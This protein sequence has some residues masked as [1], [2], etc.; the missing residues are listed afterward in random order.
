[1]SH[2]SQIGNH[3]RL[4]RILHGALAAGQVVM[5]GVF[6]FVS[7]RTGPLLG[8]DAGLVADALMAVACVALAVVL[9]WLRPRVPPRSPTVTPDA[10]WTDQ[11]VRTR[12]QLVWAVA[13]AA[14]VLALVGFLFTG[15]TIGGVVALSAM[16]VFVS[17]RPAAFEG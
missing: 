6:L 3:A 9:L 5:F 8:E 16:L 7:S 15:T 12:A 4:V 1:V 11:D 14:A 13:E 2:A 17:L 10:F